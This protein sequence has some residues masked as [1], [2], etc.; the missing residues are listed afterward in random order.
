MV[1]QAD[2]GDEDIYD[3]IDGDDRKLLIYVVFYKL[4]NSNYLL[5][6]VLMAMLH[7]VLLAIHKV[8]G[9]TNGR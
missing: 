8:Q 9:W 4:Y 2:D 6:Q 7:L 1:V 3:F 5:K